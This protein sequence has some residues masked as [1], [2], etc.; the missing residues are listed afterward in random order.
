MP[1]H[2]F[3]PQWTGAAIVANTP[4]ANGITEAVW[5]MI[6]MDA[7]GAIGVALMATH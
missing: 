7:F 3:P 2:V 4:P 5:D 1:Q 6:S